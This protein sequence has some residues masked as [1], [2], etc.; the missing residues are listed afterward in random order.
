MIQDQDKLNCDLAYMTS[1]W[2]ETNW[3][4]P[5]K[6]KSLKESSWFGES[7]CKLGSNVA[8][9]LGFYLFIYLLNFFR[10]GFLTF[11]AQIM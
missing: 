5:K 4:R 6:E 9:F 2:R 7:K 10:I 3:F 11:V 8:H 1:F